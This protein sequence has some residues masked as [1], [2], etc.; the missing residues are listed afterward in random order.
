MPA[1]RKCSFYRDSGVRYCDLDGQQTVC[2]GDLNCCEDV[3]FS[4]TSDD[5]T[6]YLQERLDEYKIAED[7]GE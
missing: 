5:L 3:K 6:Q 1:V 4:E 7:K 2:N